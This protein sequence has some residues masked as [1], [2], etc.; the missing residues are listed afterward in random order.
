M[1]IDGS[2]I[3]R[4]ARAQVKKLIGDRLEPLGLAALIVGNDPGLRQFVKLKKKAAEEVGIQFSVYEFQG[5]EVDEVKK[6]LAWLAQDE[7]IHGIFAELPM[8]KTFPQQE[9]LD[10][11][12]EA[13]DVDVLSSALQQKYYQNTASILPPAVG[14]LEYLC[15]NAHIDLKGKKVAVFGHGMLVGKPIAH[16]LAR[17]GSTVSIIDKDTKRPEMVSG[18]ADIVI[19]GVGKPGLITGDM[20]KEEAIVIDYGFSSKGKGDVDLDTVAPKASLLTP[21]PGGMGPL[22][23]AA[24]LA[25]MLIAGGLKK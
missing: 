16:W 25:N 7:G 5:D 12:P 15:D 14:A 2:L 6:T 21:V 17:Q 9:I 20:I 24:V 22:V 23:I 3:A 4:E 11:I 18:D 19:S 13:K 8:P 10:M 1:I